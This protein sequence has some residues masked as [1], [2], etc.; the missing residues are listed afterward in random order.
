MYRSPFE[1]SG[2]KRHIDRTEKTVILTFLTPDKFC[3]S[4]EGSRT[5]FAVFQQ[6]IINVA[7]I[8]RD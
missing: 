6:H 2:F 3:V 8:L 7:I 1:N 5:L 4:C